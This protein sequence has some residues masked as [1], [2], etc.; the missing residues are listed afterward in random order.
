MS[1]L[2]SPT[3]RPHPACHSQQ[4]R[5]GIRRDL[6]QPPPHREKHRTSATTSSALAAP[7]RRRANLR[8]TP[9]CARYRRSNRS[10]GSIHVQE[11]S[12]RPAITPSSIRLN[13]DEP[14]AHPTTP[15]PHPALQGG[16]DSQQHLGECW[17]P[18]PRPQSR[19]SRQLRQRPSVATLSRDTAELGS[20]QQRLQT[21]PVRSFRR[22]SRGC[23]KKASG[24]L[25]AALTDPPNA[26]AQHA[27]R[28]VFDALTVCAC[29][30]PR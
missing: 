25:N 3:V 24:G 19:A 26:S 18:P 9:A 30:V 13:N 20:A 1:V 15:T 12:N 5:N 16:T 21:T 8:T 22:R 17:R 28:V 11:S 10:R 4:P 7:P 29:R 14:C 23:P 6:I 27:P 2:A